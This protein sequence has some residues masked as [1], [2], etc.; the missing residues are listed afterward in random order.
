MRLDAAKP[1]AWR[2]VGV[3]LRQP[4]YTQWRQHHAEVGFLEVHA[5]NFFGLGGAGIQV[6]EGVRE[7][8]ELSLHGV[9]LALGSAVGVD[10]EHIQKLRRLVQRLQPMLV[11]EHACFGRA[12][13]GPIENRRIR[14]AHDLLPLTFDDEVLN[15]LVQQVCKV[16]D[17]LGRRIAIEN[18]A[19][20]LP[21]GSQWLP[22]APMDEPQFLNELVRRTGCGLLVD[23]QNLVVN[24]S[25]L[26]LQSPEWAHAAEAGEGATPDGLDE[27]ATQAVLAW[28]DAVNPAAVMQMHLAGSSGIE[29]PGD[30]VYRSQPLLIDDHSAAP[31]QTSWFCFAYALRRFGPVASLVEWDTRIPPW[32]VLL[33]QA[34]RA[35]EILGQ[36]HPETATSGPREAA[37]AWCGPLS[38][39][40]ARVFAPGSREFLRQQALLEAVQPTLMSAAAHRESMM[41]AEGRGLAAY[42][43]HA[44]ML[45]ERV[46]RQA[47]PVLAAVM[48]DEPFSALAR[49]FWVACGPTEGD[50]ACWGGELAAF[51]ASQVQLQDFPFLPE[52]ADLEWAVARA[53]HAADPPLALSGLLDLQNLPTQQVRLV[54]APG[55]VMLRPRWPVYTLWRAH[56]DAL[57][58]PGEVSAGSHLRG[59][60]AAVSS[61]PLGH[62]A[63]RGEDLGDG[64]PTAAEPALAA[65]AT[66]GPDGADSEVIWIWRQGWDVRVCAVNATQQVWLQEAQ[67]AGSLDALIRAA[68]SRIEAKR[69]APGDQAAETFAP[70]LQ[71]AVANGWVVGAERL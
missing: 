49:A 42:R 26:I 61:D 7:R 11:S 35:G 9:G 44:G 64:L 22:H 68:V 8:C 34:H 16:Q 33:E 47:Y 53:E 58:G 36:I 59:A 40:S 39:E 14:H 3:G 18:L 43:T 57:I 21:R 17:A 51:M 70:W 13:H 24:A 30:S 54:L 52:L 29:Q 50:L 56:Q 65:T 5:E 32:P 27:R 2:W 55:S 4:H 46:L 41:T 10:A 37:L 60:A 62:H 6:I 12:W 20:Y 63:S 67:T 28:L 45:A 1:P 48:G 15:G 19:V 23:I 25:N 38:V 69:L 66:Q 71:A 31:S